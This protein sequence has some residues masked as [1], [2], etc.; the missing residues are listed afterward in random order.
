MVKELRCGDVMPGCDFVAR[1]ATEEEV[2]KRAA[3]HAQEKH[4]V[5][6]LTP[7]LVV[8]VK[9]AIRTK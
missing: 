1:G 2:L 8:K 7:D 9:A 4:N 3:Q 5:K 6:Q